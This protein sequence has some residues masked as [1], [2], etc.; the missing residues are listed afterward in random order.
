MLIQLEWRLNAAV[1][2]YLALGSNISPDK[3]IPAAV[4]ALAHAFGHIVAHSSAWQTAA[5]GSAGPDFINAVVLVGSPLIPQQ[6]KNQLLRPL[7]ARRNP[8]SARPRSSGT[9]SESKWM[10]TAAIRPTFEHAFGPWAIPSLRDGT[11]IATGRA[12]AGHRQARSAFGDTTPRAARCCTT[13]SWSR[14]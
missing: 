7:E 10:T 2:V 4:D 14:A 3:N 5:V 1:R 6:I 11:S 12:A 9:T 13:I 8:R